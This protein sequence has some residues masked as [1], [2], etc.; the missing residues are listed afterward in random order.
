MVSKRVWLFYSALFCNL[1]PPMDNPIDNPP[2]YYDA[3]ANDNTNRSPSDVTGQSSIKD[4]IGA[5]LRK[6]G[7]GGERQDNGTRKHLQYPK[8]VFL[9]RH[10][11]VL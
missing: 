2:S 7:S 11:I 9:L 6:F 4:T 1:I 8:T 10:L 3:I 5:F